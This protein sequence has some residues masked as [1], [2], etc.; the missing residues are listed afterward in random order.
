ME[1]GE[2]VRRDDAGFFEGAVL[3]GKRGAAEVPGAQRRRR[4]VGRPMPIP[5]DPCSGRWT[6]TTSPKARICRLFDKLGAHLIEHEGASGI[7]FA[8]WAP[9]ARRVSVV[10]DFNEWDGR[11]HPMRKRQDIG[12]WE[13][14]VPDIGAG[15]S[16]KYEIIGPKGQKLP[17]KADP[18]AF[19]SELR[20][21]DGLDH[22]RAARPCTGATTR[23][24]S[25]WRK[26]NARRE[27]MSIYEV[28]AGSWQ[29]RDDGT[30]LSW[31]ETGRAG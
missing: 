18:F 2:L 29:R 1:A 12:I 24:A 25:F 20:P 3:I 31:D 5:S 26:A 10:G 21:G 4:M 11:R 19:H 8:V 16:Y 9:N 27:P 30:F 23:T 22:H 28:H 17:L 6:T 7:H 13:I 14:F 15:R